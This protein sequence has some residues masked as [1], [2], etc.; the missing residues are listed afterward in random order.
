[1]SRDSH[2]A[3]PPPLLARDFAE[4]HFP[5]DSREDIDLYEGVRLGIP[6]IFDIF[7][8]FANVAPT[9]V[10]H[11]RL[12]EPNHNPDDETGMFSSRRMRNSS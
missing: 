11:L 10:I 3:L 9:R 2:L 6:E 12:E 1:M 4:L 8:P 7:E 5:S